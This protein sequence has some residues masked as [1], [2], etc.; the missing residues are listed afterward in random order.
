GM[1]VMPNTALPTLE[2]TVDLVGNGAVIDGTALG[3]VANCLRIQGTVRAFDLEIHSC[4]QAPISIQD[5]SDSVV[6]G[7]F[8]HDNGWALESLN[9]TGTIIGP[10]NRITNNAGAGIYSNSAGD[11]IRGNSIRDNTQQGILVDD[12]A[13]GARI[14]GNLIVGGTDAISIGADDAIIWHNTVVGAASSAVRVGNVSG[15]DVRNNILADAGTMGIIGTDAALA[16]Q[17]YNLLFGNANDDCGAC[18]LGANSILVDPEFVDAASG[19]YRLS[20]TSPAIDAG[21]D[22]GLPFSGVAPDIGYYEVTP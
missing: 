4:P 1:V 5:S 16:E 21:I 20:P 3:G 8:L 10:G 14:T 13:I 22:V 17:D 7:C 19:D 18:T 12:L 15:V 2:G 11:Q 9:S 6:S